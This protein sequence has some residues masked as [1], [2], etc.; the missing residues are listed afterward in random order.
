MRLYTLAAVLLFACLVQ[1]NFDIT[2]WTGKW[3]FNDGSMTLC[4]DNS[5]KNVQ[6]STKIIYFDLKSISEPN[7]GFDILKGCGSKFKY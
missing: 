1:A 4:V 5:T 3:T 7:Y 6:V 2:S